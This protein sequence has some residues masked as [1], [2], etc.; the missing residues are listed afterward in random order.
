MI[1]LKFKILS[2]GRDRAIGL[3]KFKGLGNILVPQL[4]VD[5]WEFFIFRFLIYK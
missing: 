5:S 2:L 1:K 3:G 4:L